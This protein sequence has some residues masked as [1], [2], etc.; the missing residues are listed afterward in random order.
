MERARGGAE[1]PSRLFRVPWEQFIILFFMPELTNEP[2]S[3]PY[4]WAWA[5]VWEEGS[6]ILA[7]TQCLFRHRDSAQPSV[8]WDL[9]AP[10]REAAQSSKNGNVGSLE[11]RSP[12]EGYGPLA[13]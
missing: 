2:H 6:D 3:Q 8:C 10:F 11:Q 1:Q 7:A 13:S 5:R 9:A 12:R 4:A